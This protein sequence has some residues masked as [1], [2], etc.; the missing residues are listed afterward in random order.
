MAGHEPVYGAKE[1]I[2]VAVSDC[3]PLAVM[4]RATRLIPA[5]RTR[6]AKLMGIFAG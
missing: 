2:C 1:A 3:V 4:P 5:K 6:T